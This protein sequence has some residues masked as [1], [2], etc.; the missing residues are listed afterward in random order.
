MR[1][2]FNH[3]ENDPVKVVINISGY[4]SSQRNLKALSD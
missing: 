3:E 1:L 4:G 2:K